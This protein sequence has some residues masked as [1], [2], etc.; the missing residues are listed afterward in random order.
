M[1]KVSS[2][3]KG[4]VEPQLCIFEDCAKRHGQKPQ[5]HATQV[6]GRNRGYAMEDHEKSR[7]EL[8]AELLTLRSQVEELQSV[9]NDGASD[10][11][12]ESRP[13]SKSRESVISNGKDLL[14]GILDS[15]TLVSVVLTD[16]DQNVLFW[17]KGAEN[18]F[19]YKADEMVGA[20]ITRLYPPNGQ[21]TEIVERLRN[22]VRTKSG[23]VHGKMEQLTK[24]NRTLTMSLAVSPMTDPSGQV[25]G[26]LGMGLDVTQEVEQQREILRLLEQVKK[27]QDVAVFSLAKL[28]E[29][30]DE[31]TGAHLIRIQLYCQA[32]CDRLA[33]RESHADIITPEFV[34][35][36]VQSSV[37][38]DIGKVGIPDSVLMSDRKFT[39]EDLEIMKRHTIIGGR[40]LEESV[41]KL[42]RKSFLSMGK[43]IAYHHHEKW[44]GSGYPFGLSGND[45]PLS[46]RIVAVA[47]VYDALTSKRRYKKAFSHEEARDILTEGKGRHFDPDLIDVFRESDETFRGIRANVAEG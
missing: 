2:S 44:D 22:L 4:S 40:A 45:I 46:A 35:D 42:G 6:I 11:D 43:D 21:S 29:S 7:D 41:E 10:M 17:N 32:L 12:S 14:Q 20:K 25:R 18:I 27:T 36:L 15:S 23:A 9:A 16:F 26:I 13:G 47:D 39:P 3:Y 1:I 33:G 31:E 19:G 30:R 38:H 37:L 8:I 24:D 34:Q 28:A 5:S